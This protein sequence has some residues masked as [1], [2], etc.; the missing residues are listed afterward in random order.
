MAT[1]KKPTPKYP[2]INAAIDALDAK[3]AKHPK[4]PTPKQLAAAKGA[5]VSSDPLSLFKSRAKQVLGGGV[6]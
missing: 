2:T 6:D 3:K 5:A 4:R 1:K